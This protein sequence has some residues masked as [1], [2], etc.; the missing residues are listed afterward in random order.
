[1]QFRCK[2]NDARRSTFTILT[3]PY[4]MTNVAL[5]KLLKNTRNRH[6]SFDGLLRRHNFPINIKSS[7]MSRVERSCKTNT[8]K[9][10]SNDEESRF[11]PTGM[12]ES[13]RHVISGSNGQNSNP[14]LSRAACNTF[15]TDCIPRSCIGD[16]PPWDSISMR[17]SSPTPKSSSSARS[18]SD[19]SGNN[20]LSVRSQPC[21]GRRPIIINCAWF[22]AMVN[23][24][25]RMF[26]KLS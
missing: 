14:K 26:R 6:E 10:N 15:V 22:V 13:K 20:D 11:W 18:K 12:K 1:M 7:N 3:L 5:L 17:L 9:R 23:E 21:S 16:R 25:L 24:Y 8:K 4:T 2:I 19:G